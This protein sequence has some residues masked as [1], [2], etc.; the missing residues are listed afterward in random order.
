MNAIVDIIETLIPICVM[1]V[2]PIMVVWLITRARVKK[3]DQK[4]AV[5]VKAIENGVEIDPELLISETESSRNT[6]MKLIRKLTTGIVCFI[7]GV[8]LLICPCCPCLEKPDFQ[9]DVPGS[10]RLL[11]FS[12]RNDESVVYQ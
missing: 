11:I 12:D 9:C 4:M 10:P 2:L 8:A 5:L 3:N 6:K 7:I 1:C